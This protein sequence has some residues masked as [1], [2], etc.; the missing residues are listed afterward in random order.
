[1]FGRPHEERRT[2]V[3]GLGECLHGGQRRRLQ[4]A[5]ELADGPSRHVRQHSPL[6]RSACC[7]RS[8]ACGLLTCTR[9]LA[10]L[11]LTPDAYPEFGS[12]LRCG[13][14]FDRGS[15]TAELG[16]FPPTSRKPMTSMKVRTGEERRGSPCQPVS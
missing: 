8:L 10:Q 1:V 5:L 3:Q 12:T 11:N 15:A 6:G 7:W 2:R 13:S 4:S 16:G 14:S 9:C